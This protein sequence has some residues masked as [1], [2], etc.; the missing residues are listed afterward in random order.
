MKEDDRSPADIGAD[1]IDGAVGEINQVGDAK[2][3]R[4]SDGEQRINVAD[5]EAID[6]IVDEGAQ[7]PSIRN[8]LSNKEHLMGDAG[9]HEAN[10]PPHIE[11]AIRSQKASFRPTA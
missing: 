3:Q 10:V 1:R 11:R 9:A 6:R 7:K 5:D 8:S 4:E 2:N